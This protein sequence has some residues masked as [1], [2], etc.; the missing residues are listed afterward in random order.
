MD[1]FLLMY[2]VIPIVSLLLAAGVLIL[3]LEGRTDMPWRQALLTEAA[4]LGAGVA[5]HLFAAA[6]IQRM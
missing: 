4:I 1:P 6:A 3:K 5:S 2:V